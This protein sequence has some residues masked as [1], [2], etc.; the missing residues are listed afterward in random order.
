MIAAKHQQT[1]FLIIMTLM[2]SLTLSAFF[3]VLEGK[4][5]SM[6][7]GEAV[8]TW[9]PRFLKVYVA[10]VLAVIVISPLAKK[11]TMALITK[12]ESA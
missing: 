6:E 12:P 5:A 4:L 9:F 3:F 10:V 8:V 11:L 7:L 1:L 2:M